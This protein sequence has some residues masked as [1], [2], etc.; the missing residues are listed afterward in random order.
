MQVLTYIITEKK[1]YDYK[2][3]DLTKFISVITIKSVFMTNDT[4]VLCIPY[5]KLNCRYVFG[6]LSRVINFPRTNSVV[7]Q[8]GSCRVGWS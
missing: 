3:A 4:C 6:S 7:T 2:P 1:L 8:G 5:N